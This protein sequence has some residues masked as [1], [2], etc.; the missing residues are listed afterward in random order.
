MIMP[1]STIP[2]LIVFTLIVIRKLQQLAIQQLMQCYLLCN[3]IIIEIVDSV[4]HV[5]IG[6]ITGFYKI[7]NDAIVSNSIIQI[8]FCNSIKWV[9]LHFNSQH[10]QLFF[11]QR[12]FLTIN[13]QFDFMHSV[14]L[15]PHEVG[16]LFHERHND[17]FN[18]AFSRFH[19]RKIHTK[20]LKSIIPCD[21]KYFITVVIPYAPM[22][23][24]TIPLR[25]ILTFVIIRILQQFTVEQLMKCDLVGEVLIIEIIMISKRIVVERRA[26]IVAT[27]RISVSAHKTINFT[28]CNSF[29]RILS[30]FNSQ[31]F[32]LFI[33]QFNTFAVDYCIIVVHCSCSS[34]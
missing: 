3:K 15:S 18:R 11:S 6:I 27:Y 32:Q 30:F 23:I 22:P 10:L 4:I 17:F 20:I 33:R 16:V 13:C 2:R 9:I 34:P 29:K 31:R 5:L 14:L 12:N 26:V 25:C 21:T 24:V 7:V 28:F 19:R 1:V 8:T